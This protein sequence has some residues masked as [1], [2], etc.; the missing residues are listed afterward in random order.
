MAD[1]EVEG[2][3]AEL[4]QKLG[5]A[6]KRELGAVAREDAEA[7][8]RLFAV[9]RADRSRGDRTD[10]SR[11]RRLEERCGQ[12][13]RAGSRPRFITRCIPHRLVIGHR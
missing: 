2:R 1:A 13:D 7:R 4:E 12:V 8:K 6:R 11:T 10:H 5:N 3:V 9:P